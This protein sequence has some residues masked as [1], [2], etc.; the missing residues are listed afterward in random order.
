MEES[1]SFFSLEAEETAGKCSIGEKTGK[2]N[3]AEGKIPVLSC[4]GEGVLEEKLRGLPPIW[5]PRKSH[6]FIG[7]CF[8]C[9][10]Q[11]HQHFP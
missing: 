8:W 6:K 11:I 4:E 10:P 3:Q 7:I 9:S 5:W 2:Q 1:M